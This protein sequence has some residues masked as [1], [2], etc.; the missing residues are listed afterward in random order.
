MRWQY[1]PDAPSYAAQSAVD[2][3][4]L[5]I[6]T[7]SHKVYAL[8]VQTGQPLWTADIG[9]NWP[10]LGI[11]TGI[12]ISGDTVYAGAVKR[13]T[14]AGDSSVS[15][16][17]ALDRITGTILFEFEARQAPATSSVSSAPVVSGTL[18]LVSDLGGAFY[19]I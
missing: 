3:G 6:G 17:A 5:Y 10:F 16:V 12:A 18:L 2:D 7:R 14:S 11:V 9:V 15:I 4:A 19:A 8:D 13:L 1:S